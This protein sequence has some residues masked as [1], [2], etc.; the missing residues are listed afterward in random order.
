MPDTDD[1]QQP[2]DTNP[3]TSD[4]FALV[5]H[6]IR[7]EIIQILGSPDSDEF[8]IPFGEL[9]SRMDVDVDP[10]QLHYHLDQLV[11][12][13]IERTE[14]G[15]HIRPE[16]VRLYLT[17]RAGALDQDRESLALD[18]SF[19]CHTCQ[20]PVEAS[21]TNGVVKV[22]CPECGHKYG[23]DFLDIALAAFEDSESSFSFSHFCK[24]AFRKTFSLGQ[25]V[26]PSCAHPLDPQFEAAETPSS[27]P[28]VQIYQSCALCGADWRSP[29]GRVLLTGPGLR[30]FCHD[31]GVDVLTIPYW[32]LEFAA[33]DEY[34]TVRSTDPWEV[35]L[36]L[37]FDG[38][39][40]ELVVD[41]DL[42]VSERN[43]SSSGDNEAT[44]D[45]LILPDSS[46]CLDTLRRHRW[47]DGVT[48]PHCDSTETTKEGTTAKGAQR[49]RCHA[50]N[51][52]FNDLTGTVF[53]GRL[54]TLP[55]M[56]HIVGEIEET[57]PAQIA[58]DLDRSYES[59]LDFVHV[60]RDN[61]DDDPG[62]D[63]S[64][65]CESTISP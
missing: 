15:Y 31:H 2:S 21:F 34:V 14:D 4:V 61:R 24:F 45:D 6:E 60:V 41:G 58:R 27:H 1:G 19:D 44:G 51:T 17:V 49:Y 46:A 59:V 65:V 52:I 38:E 40:L 30:S 23:H 5:G 8:I 25:G 54:F 56:F 9:R 57:K 35:A 13:Y 28:E 20:G 53:A 29:V 37:T 33:T 47:P 63:L 7:A 36:A 50:C 22:W 55:E 62:F 16:G 3:S 42:N 43:R 39:T 12:H 11:G 18:P 26:C 32:E 64:D 48:C 10:S